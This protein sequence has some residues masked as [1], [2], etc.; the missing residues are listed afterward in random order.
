MRVKLRYDLYLY[1]TIANK[2]E[3]IK[4][5]GES[6]TVCSTRQD[7]ESNTDCLMELHTNVYKLRH[8]SESI[9][10]RLR[11]IPLRSLV[12]AEREREG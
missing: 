6:Q 9:S 7:V 3:I 8:I 12:R 5:L 4:G 2:A 1:R 11:V 10:Y